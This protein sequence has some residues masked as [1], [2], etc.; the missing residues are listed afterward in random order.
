MCTTCLLRRWAQRWLPHDRSS[1]NDA[2][3]LVQIAML[4]TLSRLREFQV[5]SDVGFAAYLRQ[6]LLNEVRAELRRHR[7][8]GETVEIDE[9]LAA[10]GDPVVEQALAH[11][12]ERAFRCAL[13]R[14][15]RRQR[16]HVTLRMEA[17]LSFG[18]I[19]QHVGGNADSARMIVARVAR[20]AQ[21]A[22]A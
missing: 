5:R 11:E 19:A 2:D 3:D 18:E 17:G 21:L 4:R 13:Q 20:I 9:N 7:R 1:F 10:E 22:A 8:S 15:D 12:R 6:I 16:E 14:L